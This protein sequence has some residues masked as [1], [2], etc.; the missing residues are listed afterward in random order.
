MKRV[1]LILLTAAIIIQTSVFAG[2]GESADNE[3]IIINV[4]DIDTMQ[5]A[6]E[7]GKSS[8]EI[9]EVGLPS[10]S[11]RIV[12]EEWDTPAEYVI[13]GKNI[14]IRGG[15]YSYRLVIRSDKTLTFDNDLEVY[16][17]GVNGKYKLHYDIDK[18]DNHTMIVTGV[19]D[20]IIISSPLLEKLT[21]EQRNWI[22]THISKDSYFYKLILKTKEGFSFQNTLRYLVDARQHGYA[23]KYKY[24]LLTDSQ[25]LVICG[26]PCYDQPKTGGISAG[27]DEP[28]PQPDISDPVSQPD[29]SMPVSQPDT[30]E[31]DRQPEAQPVNDTPQVSPPAPASANTV[32]VSYSKL[33]KRPLTI[34]ASRAIGS[35]KKGKG[36]TTYSKTSGNAKIKVNKRNGNITVKKGLARGT[37]EVTVKVKSTDKNKSVSYDTARFIVEVA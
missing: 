4:S 32:T 7:S 5:L 27:S 24:D 26:L 15:T 33:K 3:K 21:A 37:Y 28:A 6:G 12:S 8:T 18:T 23:I 36:K 14:K 13:S 34:K 9:E 10:D 16:Y 22:L 1:F 20:N 30:S 29:E 31:P 2:F 35:V 19:F 17:Q 25:T 11:L